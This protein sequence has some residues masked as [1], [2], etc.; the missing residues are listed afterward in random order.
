[1]VTL[2]AGIISGIIIVITLINAIRWALQPCN[3][4]EQ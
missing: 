1:M 2:T 4:E 3:K